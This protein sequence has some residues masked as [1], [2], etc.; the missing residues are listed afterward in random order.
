[1]NAGRPWGQPTKRP[2]TRADETAYNIKHKLARGL[3]TRRPCSGNRYYYSGAYQNRSEYRHQRERRGYLR[4]SQPVDEDLTL[5]L[6]II[7]HKASVNDTQLKITQRLR[8][9]KHPPERRA[10]DITICTVNCRERGKGTGPTQAP[11]ERQQP[12]RT[13]HLSPPTFEQRAGRETTKPRR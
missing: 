12:N 9:N 6:L 7:L 5:M 2:T 3:R 10:P 8:P 4:R 13:A 11:A 1:M